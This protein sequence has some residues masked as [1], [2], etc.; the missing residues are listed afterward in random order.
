MDADQAWMDDLEDE[1]E[2]PED[3][4]EYWEDDELTPQELTAWADAMQ[5]ASVIP[6]PAAATR[7]GRAGPDR[8]GA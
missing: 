2:P 6:A 8:R 1:E 3:E 7:R 5:A 4:P